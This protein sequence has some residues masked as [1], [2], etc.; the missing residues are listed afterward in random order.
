MTTTA[1]IVRMTVLTTGR[2]FGCVAI[3][4]SRNGREIGRGLVV[5]TREAAAEFGADL[6]RR[7]GW[8]LEHAA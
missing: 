2:N 3:I 4:K 1:R 8:L 5:A 7:N 6:A